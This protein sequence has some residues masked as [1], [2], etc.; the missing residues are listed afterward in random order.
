MV[1]ETSSL[2]GSVTVPSYVCPPLLPKDTINNGFN[3]TVTNVKFKFKDAPCAV[4]HEGYAL[5][6]LYLSGWIEV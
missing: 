1:K 5:L 2:F 4:K 3:G 6:S